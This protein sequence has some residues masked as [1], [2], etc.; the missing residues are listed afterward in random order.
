VGNKK[1]LRVF[2]RSKLLPF[3]IGFKVGGRRGAE[4]KE[5]EW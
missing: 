2:E 3:A 4:E 5:R 1:D